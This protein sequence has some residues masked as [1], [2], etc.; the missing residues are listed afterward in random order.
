MTP[1]VL[2]QAAGSIANVPAVQSIQPQAAGSPPATVIALNRMAYGPRPG[3]VA[4]INATGGLAAYI[5]RQL[6]P[7]TIDDSACEA[8]VAAAKLRIRYAAVN[9]TRPL[10]NLNKTT[11]QLWA[12]V[13]TDMMDFRERIRPAE[14]VRVATLIRSCYSERQLQQ[15]M[16]EFWHNH[17]NVRPNSDQNIS[18]MFPAYHAV[19]RQHCFGRFRT[20]L[21]EIGKST[22]MMYDLDNVSNRAAGG[23]GG[24]ENYSRE[25]FELQTLGSDNYLKFYDNR[26]NIGTINY[27]SETF[28]RGYIDEDVYEAARC[29]SG[30]TISNDH[31]EFPNTPEYNDGTFRYYPGWHDT[32]P[33]TVLSP[34]GI[35][36]IP[37]NQAAMKDGRDVFDLLANHIGTA[38]YICTKL[39]RRLIADSPPQSV[40]DA[41]V[42]EWMAHRQSDDQ[43]KRVLRVILTSAAFTSTWGQ[44]V[45]RPFE[46]LISFMRAVELDFVFDDESHPEGSNWSRLFSLLE[47]TGHGMFGWPTPTGYPDLASFWANTNGTLRRWSLPS[48]IRRTQTPPV[49][50]EANV[51]I[52]IRGKTTTALG[53]SATSEQIVDYWIGRLFGY[54]IGATTRTELI[55]FLAQQRQANQAPQV[56]SNSPE[57][58]S[59]EAFSERF[60]NMIELMAMS[61]EFQYR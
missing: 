34:T 42:A 20:M 52:D 57:W 27:G 55:T 44:K 54:S 12:I 46:M 47:G 40:V 3:D 37:R 56:R 24:N 16:V 29:F 49:T 8:K 28:V 30:W 10:S 9:E 38:R 51:V 31:W 36:N 33:K 4:A 25:L 39:C 61:P 45:K 14:E 17:F 32:N 19:I 58:N 6:A 35:P 21:E 48:A 50:W 26:A 2:T 53:S 23:E 60:N 1:Q 22:A 5:E 11:P 59:N 43:I 18:S 7:D 41:A 15:V 13:A